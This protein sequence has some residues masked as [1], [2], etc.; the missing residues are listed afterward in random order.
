LTRFL[1]IGWYG[2][3]PQIGRSLSNIC[4]GF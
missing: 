4:Q 2:T 3:L 1:K